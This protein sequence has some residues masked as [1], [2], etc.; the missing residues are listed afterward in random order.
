MKKRMM[1][2]LCACAVVLS[3]P[4][5]AAGESETKE[6]S[7]SDQPVM[8]ESIEE[9]W[10]MYLSLLADYNQ[11]KS[12][13]E[14]LKG[15]PADSAYTVTGDKYELTITDAYIFDSYD[16]YGTTKAAAEGNVFVGLDLDAK[17]ITEEDDYFNWF[18]FDCYSDGYSKDIDMNIKCNLSLMTGDVK[19]GRHLTGSIA[20][21]LP[22]D[23]SDLEIFYAEDYF[24][25]SIKLSIT[26]DSELFTD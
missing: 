17:N 21:E 4:A 1:S 20:F 12:E 8:P 24:G 25:D 14:A 18:N 19:A 7:V 5:Y 13:M 10:E 2:V 15:A 22:A 9:L 11:L 16:Y 23:W 6:A 3:M 26:P